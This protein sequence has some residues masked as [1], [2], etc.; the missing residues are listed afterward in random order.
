MLFP[1]LVFGS[2]RNSR[3]EIRKYNFSGNYL[4]ALSVDTLGILNEYQFRGFTISY[5]STSGVLSV[6]PEGN[7]RPLLFWKDPEPLEVA[8]FGFR[9]W[10]SN[11]Y[12]A[13][14]NCHSS[15]AIGGKKN[16]LNEVFLHSVK[17]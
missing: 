13:A 11:I 14:F 8:Y 12:L 10:E 9:T 17:N 1:Q 16:F 7:D 5:N 15:E 6:T 2:G 4:E 3:S